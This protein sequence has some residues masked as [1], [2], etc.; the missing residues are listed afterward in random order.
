MP[1][2]TSWNLNPTASTADVVPYDSAIR[3]YDVST[4][5]YDS[6]ASGNNPYNWKNASVWTNSLVYPAQ[7]Q[8]YGGPSYVPLY[9]GP[10]AWVANPGMVNQSGQYV[11]SQG[12]NADLDI[13]DNSTDSFDGSNTAVASNYD[14]TIAGIP[15]DNWKSPTA[16]APITGGNDF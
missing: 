11:S 12:A 7:Q 14:S 6:Y 9:G 2:P 16:W 8:Y 3:E 13:Y 5:P 1:N 4:Q 10:T 15:I